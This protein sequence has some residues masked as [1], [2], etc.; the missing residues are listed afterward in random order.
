MVEFKDILS[1]RQIVRK[2]LPPTPL[3]N[4]PSLDQIVGEKVWVKHEN[5]QPIGAFKVRGGINFIS[6]LS[7][8]ER[9]AGVIT[10]STGNHGQSI[11]YAARTFGVKAIIVVPQNANPVKVAAISS[12]G[13]EI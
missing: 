13:A 2:Y 4:Y 10:A 11:A 5:Y 7:N 1:A 9:Q 12:Y 8:E 6:Q 3:H